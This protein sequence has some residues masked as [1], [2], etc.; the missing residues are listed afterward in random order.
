MAQV[1]IKIPTSF[2]TSVNK[3]T[4][5]IQKFTTI[6]QQTNK[7]LI[8]STAKALNVPTT[9]VSQMTR[10]QRIMTKSSATI[11]RTLDMTINMMGTFGKYF[12][13]GLGALGSIIGLMTGPVGWMIT[14]ATF[15]FNITTMAA[16]FMATIG[17]WVWDKMVGLGDSMLKDFLEATGADASMGGLRAFRAAFRGLPDDPNIVG[18]IGQGKYDATT[19]QF[20]VMKLLGVKKQKDTADMAVQ[21]VLAAAAFMKSKPKGL[22]LAQ[23]A[24]LGLTSIFT[25]EYLM[26]LRNVEGQELDR[27]A[28]EYARYKEQL[29][30]SDKAIEGWISF[31]MQVDSVGARITKII[32]EKMADPDS[33]FVQALNK[34]SESL[35]HFVKTFV[36]M[37]EVKD[38]VRYII[39]WMD[40]LD[41]WI[42]SGG[43]KKT[44]MDAI[45]WIKDVIKY[46]IYAGK[47]VINLGKV[48]MGGIITPANAEEV[49]ASWKQASAKGGSNADLFRAGVR[50]AAGGGA[51]M[52]GPGR[53]PTVT[54][55]G[56]S[57]T[58]RSGQ[59][60]KS[61]TAQGGSS[62]PARSS[63]QTQKSGTAQG[64]P[65]V[66]GPAAPGQDWPRPGGYPKNGYPNETAI[67]EAMRQQLLAEGA[68]PEAAEAGAAGLAGQSISE[69][70]MRSQWHDIRGGNT[71][72][73]VQSIYGADRARGQQMVNWLRQQGLDPADPVNQAKW[74][75]HEVMTN[76]RFAASRQAIENAKK[77]NPASMDAMSDTLTRNYEAP[78]DQGPGQLNKRRRDTRYAAGIPIPKKTDTTSSSPSSKPPAP[79]NQP[80][81]RP[82]R[83]FVP[84]P[85]APSKPI[86]FPSKPELPRIPG[87]PPFVSAP[88]RPR[89]AA[90]LANE[91]R[92]GQGQRDQ[93]QRASQNQPPYNLFPAATPFR[94][95]VAPRPIEP[96]FRL[97]TAPEVPRIPGQRIVT[98]PE[99]PRTAADLANQWRQEQ[100][101]REGGPRSG[102]TRTLAELVVE[103]QRKQ[104]S[105]NNSATNAKGPAANAPPPVFQST[106]V[107]PNELYKAARAKFAASPLNGFVPKDGAR[108]GIKTGSP[109]EYARLAVALAKQ[110]SDFG[111]DTKGA[112][113]YQM[114]ADD[115]RR[116]GQKNPDTSNSN[117]ELDAMVNQVSQYVTKSGQMAGSGTGPGTYKGQA[118]AAAFFEPFQDKGGGRTQLDKHLVP[119]GLADQIQTSATG[120]PSPATGQTTSAPAA[121]TPSTVQPPKTI[122]AGAPQIAQAKTQSPGWQLDEK[123]GYKP[124]NDEFEGGAPRELVLHYT[125]GNTHQ[126]GEGY[127]KAVLTPGSRESRYHA[128]LYMDENGVITRITPYGKTTQH[129]GPGSYKGEGMEIATTY[130]GHN[131]NLKGSGINDKQRAALKEYYL[132]ARKSGM[133]PDG[134]ESHSQAVSA[135]DPGHRVNEADWEANWLRDLEAKNAQANPAPSSKE[136]PPSTAAA[137]VSSGDNRKAG[138]Q[139]VNPYSADAMNMPYPG[140]PNSTSVTPQ[141]SQPPPT[142]SS[143]SSQPVKMGAFPNQNDRPKDYRGQITTSWDNK[144]YPYR[145]GGLGGTEGAPFGN[146]PLNPEVLP[147]QGGKVYNSQNGVQINNN[148]MYDPKLKRD[149]TV[150]YI[151]AGYHNIDYEQ[152]EGCIVVRR[153]L[154]TQLATSIREEAKK[155]GPLYMSIN[156]DFS[157]RISHVNPQSEQPQP[158][159]APRTE[160]GTPVVPGGSPGSGASTQ[161]QST[162]PPL[163]PAG[164]GAK[165]PIM[166]G[167]KGKPGGDQPSGYFDQAAFERHARALG[168][169]PRVIENSGVLSK[170]AAVAAAKKDWIANGRGPVGFYGF[171]LGTSRAAAAATD[172]DFGP[173]VTKVVTIGTYKGAGLK[174]LNGRQ[175]WDNY[176]DYSSVDEPGPQ[177]AGFAIPTQKGMTNFQSH[178]KDQNV[179][180][181][182]AAPLDT[183]AT[184]PATGKKFLMTPASDVTTPLADRHYGGLTPP[185]K[186]YETAEHAHVRPE[187]AVASNVNWKL[188][189]AEYIARLNAAYRKLPPEDQAKIKMISGYRPTT[190]ADAISLGMS[191]HSSQEYIYK[192][193]TGVYPRDYNEWK[194]GKPAKAARPGGSAHESGEGSD[195]EGYTLL[196]KQMPNTFAEARG[197]PNHLQMIHD[198]RNL[199][200]NEPKYPDD[201]LDDQTQEAAKASPVF[202][203][204]EKGTKDDSAYDPGDWVHRAIEKQNKEKNKDKEEKHDDNPYQDTKK[205]EVKVKNEGSPESDKKKKV[206]EHHNSPHY[207]DGFEATNKSDHDLAVVDY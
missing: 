57:Y 52:L 37:P 92:Q 39:K 167:F 111:R 195:L 192:V 18:N 66:Q 148:V 72:G 178:L 194:N 42:K 189:N 68:S 45:R 166:Y 132:N 59:T 101:Q 38:G 62:G 11:Q 160:Q 64:A 107:D 67:K 122:P 161:Q 21:T 183:R 12:M 6:A 151:H 142:S 103:N 51:Q 173:N 75:A 121:A 24:A 80:V 56:A 127:S 53:G 28:K 95:R 78:G 201:S 187:F 30:L 120:Q 204:G 162:N 181:N 46:A 73:R 126:T 43:A 33:G 108:W 32:A 69:S 202:R 82:A 76:K 106:R 74:M 54:P 90:D 170:D 55:T 77:S 81:N 169:E 104:N 88:E 83:E 155:N 96:Q 105:I 156:P 34:L 205:G 124:T 16:T 9:V 140:S 85:A 3:L 114:S 65:A 137:P 115:L 100:A 165:K 1:N 130:G 13:R 31:K 109:D 152:S 102:P 146:W 147:G 139:A 44:L 131:P 58:T 118:G 136:S 138:Q 98:F 84:K 188:M 185:G 119:G 193:F 4:A 149:R 23:A 20:L 71:A 116:Y 91:W 171:S 110:E 99:R 163:P 8:W 133:Y 112:G 179:V 93:H 176:P 128:Q 41:D 87:G 174:V 135:V 177:G 29:K 79:S 123:Y 154:E 40:E 157:I 97:P 14:G 2:F 196:E 186:D 25:P 5:D 143:S 206:D 172:P 7:N 158:S 49:P 60:R 63:G 70:G 141:P 144:S 164:D 129:A 117:Q 180:A 125:G 153:D 86:Q 203:P 191:P 17:K 168:Y 35:V 15:V 61:G 200:V 27:M 184:D 113:L 36:N 199:L 134:V 89:T 94:D 197:D 22:S 159:S 48:F 47:Q 182:Q 50:G 145:T 19:K 207:D 190:E 175:D 26:A 198:D 10:L 150:I